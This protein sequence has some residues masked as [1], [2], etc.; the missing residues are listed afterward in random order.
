MCATGDIISPEI[1]SSKKLQE[2][3]Y[4][5]NW[6]HPGGCQESPAVEEAYPKKTCNIDGGFEDNCAL[7]DCWFNHFCSL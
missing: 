6:G 7:L 5:S 4:I 1:N 2:A 3:C